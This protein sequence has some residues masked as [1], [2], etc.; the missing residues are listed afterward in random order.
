MTLTVAQEAP[1]SERPDQEKHTT[2]ITKTKEAMAFDALCVGLTRAGS[3]TGGTSM[4]YEQY[5][6]ALSNC[7]DALRETGLLDAPPPAS[8]PAGTLDAIRA[9]LCSAGIDHDSWDY[10]ADKCLTALNEAG[11]F[12][13][14][15]ADVIREA[16]PGAPIHTEYDVHRVLGRPLDEGQAEAIAAALLAEFGGTLERRFFEAKPNVHPAFR[17]IKVTLRENDTAGCVDANIF[18]DVH[19]EEA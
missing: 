6:V 14:S 15:P 1:V 4:D 8:A 17:S 5:K 18:Y 13:K 3:A 11:L 16:M 19:P 2:V 10:V 12:E 9:G 7:M